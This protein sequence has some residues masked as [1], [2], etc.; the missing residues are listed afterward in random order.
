MCQTS[1]EIQITIEK[2]TV[3]LTIVDLL[4]IYEMLIKD[5]QTKLTTQPDSIFQ[6]STTKICLN[7]KQF[8]V[9]TFLNDIVSNQVQL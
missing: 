5:G 1:F 9:S 4:I 8:I 7:F 3:S 6:V 2:D